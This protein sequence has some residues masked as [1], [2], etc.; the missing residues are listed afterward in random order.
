[1]KVKTVDKIAEGRPNVVD[2]IK[3]G[4]IQMVINTPSGGIPRCDENI[5][6]T[7]AV[8]QRLCIIT[9]MTGAKAA[10]LGIESQKNKS[11]SVCPL[12]TYNADVS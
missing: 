2:L 5:I 6:R 11:L 9:T 3:N 7:A 8:K 1:M 12:Q 10:L 4:Q